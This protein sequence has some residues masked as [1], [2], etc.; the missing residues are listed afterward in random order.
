M[1]SMKDR[2]KLPNKP[3]IYRVLDG[4][5]NVIYVGQ[6]QDIRERWKNKKHHKLKPIEEYCKKKETEA[7][8]DW[9]LVPKKL[10]NRVENCA[11]EFYDPILNASTPPLV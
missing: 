4:D 2:D 9:V 8:I 7:F 6:A 10:L 1:L 5:Q 3:G 11:V